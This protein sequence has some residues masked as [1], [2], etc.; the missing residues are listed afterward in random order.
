MVS[1]LQPGTTLQGQGVLLRQQLVGISKVYLN[2]CY[3]LCCSV[4]RRQ[5]EVLFLSRQAESPSYDFRA[6]AQ[7]FEARGWKTHMH[8]K[9]V[10]KRNLASYFGHVMKEIE[11]IA[12][13]KIV[14]LDRYDPIISLLDFKSESHPEFLAPGNA[15]L[16]ID[17]PTEPI[18]IQLWHAF[19]AYKKFGYQSL[20]TPEGHSHEV[21]EIFNIHRNYS[22][23]VCSSSECRQ[24]FAEAFSYPLDRVI[25]LNRPEFNELL[26]LCKKQPNPPLERQHPTVLFAPTLRKSKISP[27]PFR[28][29][30]E[31]REEYLSGLDADIIWSFHPLESN[32]PAPGNVSEALL[33]ADYVITD[34]SSIVYEAYLLNKKV[35]FYIPDIE[36]YR[37]SPGLNVD[38]VELAPA[39]CAFDEKGLVSMLNKLIDSEDSYPMNDLKSFTS[40]AFDETTMDFSIFIENL[41]S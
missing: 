24:A 2:T 16:H 22:L 9:K 34:Y 7:M 10:S 13:C 23:I 38:P 17:F 8:L 40:S 28:K 11:L 27:H 30:Y 26:A 5:N 39:L 18:V 20:G 41:L 36:R 12:R 15:H 4:I 14:I 29:L 33:E 3:Q 6:L 32:L 21:T 19:G 25:P 1:S 35:L 31:K 37:K